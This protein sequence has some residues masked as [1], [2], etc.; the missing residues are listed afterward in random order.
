LSG[1]NEN[2]Q[3][4]L[5]RHRTTDA[6]AEQSRCDKQVY[7]QFPHDFP[8]WVLASIV[9]KTSVVATFARTWTIRRLATAATAQIGQLLRE[10][11]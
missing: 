6:P 2:L 11:C 8:L 4:F 9:R 7:Y 10:R 5:C 3:R 1:Q